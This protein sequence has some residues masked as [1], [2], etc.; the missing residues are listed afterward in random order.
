MARPLRVQR[1]REARRAMRRLGRVLN[2][3]ALS[4][5]L[6][7][8][9]GQAARAQDVAQE[10]P[11]HGKINWTDK[12]ITVTGSGAPNLKAANVAVARLGA[13]RAAKM[14]AFRNIL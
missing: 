5:V 13:E 7:V 8:A 4:A 6:C 11:G 2:V 12:T 14:D 9:T 1:A 3:G 10:V